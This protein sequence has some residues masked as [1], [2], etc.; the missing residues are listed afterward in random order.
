MPMPV[1]ISSMP[2][3][4][5]DQSKRQLRA[6]TD[7]LSTSLS[8]D[9]LGGQFTYLTTVPSTP[10]LTSLVHLLFEYLCTEYIY[11]QVRKDLSTGIS[12]DEFCGRRFPHFNPKDK[13]CIE[14]N[15]QLE[16]EGIPQ[17]C[18]I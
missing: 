13:L 11:T 18:Y 15:P 5:Y 10:Q 17:L 16:S 1:L 9:Q 2:M 6:Q 4:S 8:K 7:D 12:K 14:S 3:P